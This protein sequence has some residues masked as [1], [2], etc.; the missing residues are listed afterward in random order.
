MPIPHAGPPPQ[1]GP[2]FD[3][4]TG[5]TRTEAGHDP[6]H[7]ALRLWRHYAASGAAGMRS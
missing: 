4:A 5:G 7:D 2:P 6:A 3:I 1:C